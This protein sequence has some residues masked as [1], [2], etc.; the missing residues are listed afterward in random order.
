MGKLAEILRDYNTNSYVK[1][2]HNEVT[3]GRDIKVGMSK[4]ATHYVFVFGLPIG[5]TTGD[6]SGKTAKI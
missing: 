1:Y 6:R 4:D 5:P 3:L 2:G